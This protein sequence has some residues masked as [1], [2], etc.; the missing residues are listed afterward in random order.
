MILAE[1]NMSL[2]EYTSY[3]IGG[4][5]RDVYFPSNA[6]ELLEVLEHLVESKTPFFM[7]AGGSN[8]LVGDAFFDGAVIIMTRMDSFTMHEDHLVCGAGL[9]S[10]RAA[11]IALESGKSGLE[12]LYKLPGTVGG[13]LAGNARFSDV[14][15]S[16]VLLSVTAVHPEHGKR[17]FDQ[18]TLDFAYK[19]NS[20]T[21]G[22]WYICELTLSW[23]DGDK[24]AIES[25]MDEID[26]FRKERHHFDHPSCGCI[27]K[28]DHARNIQVGR[29]IDSLALKGTRVGGAEIADF[30]ANFIVNTGNATARD[31]L[32]L[33]EKVERIVMEEKG[34]TLE[35]EV[36]LY[37]NFE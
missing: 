26:T 2:A 31:V 29:L 4:N 6:D 11:E 8:V 15:V 36:K 35:R 21:L 34:L 28:N 14:N 23:L 33:I 1:H 22:G 3:K 30:H 18:S 10:T 20:L 17:V 5:A 7:L 9:S 12:F 25:R 13:G 24:V 19:K 27:F 16:D 37:G 32:D